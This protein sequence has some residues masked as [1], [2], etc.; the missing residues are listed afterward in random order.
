MK[1]AQN[2]NLPLHFYGTENSITT[3]KEYYKNNS[4][5]LII[6]YHIDKNVDDNVTIDTGIFAQIKPTSLLIVIFAHESSISYEASSVSIINAL[7]SIQ[8]YINFLVIIPEQYSIDTL[9]HSNEI[10]V[11]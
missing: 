10:A 4:N 2:T 9:P 6:N 1:M 3:I 11:I 8:N 5:N 7:Q